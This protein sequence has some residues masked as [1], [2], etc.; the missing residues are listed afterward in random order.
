MNEPIQT[1]RPSWVALNAVCAV[2]GAVVVALVFGR[3][4]S[5]VKD[6]DPLP[7]VAVLSVGVLGLVVGTVYFGVLALVGFVFL[8]GD[9]K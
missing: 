9:R 1:P 6:C 4:V 8:V 3:L 2:A 7:A 5:A